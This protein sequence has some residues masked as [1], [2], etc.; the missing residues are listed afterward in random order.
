MFS[1]TTDR[2]RLHSGDWTTNQD[3]EAKQGAKWNEWLFSEYVPKTW[4][5]NLECLRDISEQGESGFRAWDFWPAGSNQEWKTG[6]SGDVTRVLGNVF[7]RAVENDLRLLPTV[8]GT[9]GTRQDVLFTLEG[10]D[11]YESAFKDAGV[12]VVAPPHTK[13]H[14]LMRLNTHNL[15][16]GLTP[17]AVRERLALG[18]N[19]EN[20]PQD[21]RM[22]LLDYA[23]S[24]G[25]YKKIG[26][27]RAPLIPVKDGTFQSFCV[28]REKKT[29][30]I[31]LPRDE[32]EVQLFENHS[33]IV[34]VDMLL[35]ETAE[36]MRKNINDLDRHTEISKWTM[37]AAA[38]YCEKHI[39]PCADT[40]I[41]RKEGLD[42][43]V[44]RLWQ[45]IMQQN[46]P[47]SSVV[48]SPL[49]NMWLI[50]LM[51]REYRK[52]SSTVQILDVSGNGGIGV[53]IWK[54]AKQY[55]IRCALFTGEGI[56]Q[57][58]VAYLRLCG[59]LPY[60]GD[61]EDLM[62]WL[63]A[64]SETFVDRLSS[65]EKRL[66]LRH[67]SGLASDC[68]G[69]KRKKVMRDAVASL[70]IFSISR[71]F[72][73]SGSREVPVANDVDSN[74]W[75]SMNGADAHH[76]PVTYIG[77]K[78]IP[79]TLRVPGTVFVNIED[80]DTTTLIDTLE[81][82]HCPQPLEILQRYIVP[83]IVNTEDNKWGGGCQAAIEY[84]L[85]NFEILSAK[86]KAELRQAK[87]VPVP[88]PAG[89]I[90]RKRPGDTLEPN[91]PVVPLFFSDEYKVAAEPFC[92]CYRD[93]L[94]ELGMVGSINNKVILERIGEYGNSNR[95]RSP[96]DI[97]EKAQLL[98]TG[99]TPPPFTSAICQL[100]W[101]P[102]LSLD[103]KMHLYSP[104]K[105]RGPK[106][107]SLVKYALPLV[108]FPI[109]NAWNSHLGWDQPLPRPVILRQLEGAVKADDIASLEY[110][111]KNKHI[112][113]EEFPNELNTVAWIPSTTG[114]YYSPANIFLDDFKNLSPHLGTLNS[115]FQKYAVP[116]FSKIGVETAPSLQ[117]VST[118]PPTR[119][120]GDGFTWNIYWAN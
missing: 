69:S 100:S 114:D 105:C 2:R 9:T 49:R 112:S 96:E 79:V 72:T 55:E 60:H 67:L 58:T 83:G 4:L 51:D 38:R 6:E 109:S 35:P 47:S 101:I 14:E 82:A 64:N 33:R 110:L 1:I 43:F 17:C 94:L 42:Q 89:E 68:I 97:A 28:S 111:I 106:S 90:L 39:F 66:L 74:E 88:G 104:G 50:P 99:C 76:R 118:F 80:P 84:A 59:F 29:R 95:S 13:A 12:A 103:N 108:S 41:I 56:S 87:I 86:C 92:R 71:R 10:V 48:R 61:L 63:V 26:L 113:V 37:D 7:K 54:M 11:C 57:E 119:Y 73:N 91:S 5:R 77:V 52:L 53:F 107:E 117:R 70:R 81:M 120:L 3:S 32:N 93:Q 30:P 18:N 75:T 19:I 15:L 78:N 40:D 24:D 27:C 23:I 34:D 22:L 45:W 31:F 16:T 20:L 62:V 8:C 44:D 98:I 116:F 36:V 65:E 21:S 85:Q 25:D 102:A 46:E 115:Q